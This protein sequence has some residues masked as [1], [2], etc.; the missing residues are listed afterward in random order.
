MTKI[1]HPATFTVPAGYRDKIRFQLRDDDGRLIET[2]E[3]AEHVCLNGSCESPAVCEGCGATGAERII[4]IG[5]TSDGG[6][7]IFLCLFCQD[8]TA[9]TEADPSRCPNGW[10][11]TGP[12]PRLRPCPECPPRERAN[13][14]RNPESGEEV[15]PWMMP[16]GRAVDAG[17]F[18]TER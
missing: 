5:S 6:Q 1:T 14:V 10:H 8:P 9:R 16:D 13:P 4:L 7:S 3:V 12:T 11:A 15:M 17:G 2:I 18:P